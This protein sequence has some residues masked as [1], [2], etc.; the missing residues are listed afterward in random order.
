MMNGSCG[1]SKG[2]VRCDGK[3]MPVIAAQLVEEKNA[4]RVLCSC[5][6]TFKGM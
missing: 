2:S 6:V 5:I 3:V 1:Y 4:H